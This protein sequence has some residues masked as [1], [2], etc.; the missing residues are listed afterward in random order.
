[1]KRKPFSALL[2]GF[3]LTVTA[4]GQTPAASSRAPGTVF[5]DCPVC[6]EM[7]VIPAGKFTMG[8]SAD[9]KSWAASHGGNMAAID[10]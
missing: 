3:F 1:M 4:Y 2:T 6:P 5:R 9:E 7:V 10:R 8:S